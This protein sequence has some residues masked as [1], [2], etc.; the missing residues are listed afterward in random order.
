MAL[1]LLIQLLLLGINRV[2]S[3]EPFT[4][5]NNAAANVIVEEY[6]VKYKCVVFHV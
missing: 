3:A 1:L 4:A 5:W 6:L 2:D